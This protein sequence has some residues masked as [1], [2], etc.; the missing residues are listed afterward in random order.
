MNP[1]WN[2]SIATEELLVE[3]DDA[4]VERWLTTHAGNGA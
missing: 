2:R 3:T 1:N 4:L